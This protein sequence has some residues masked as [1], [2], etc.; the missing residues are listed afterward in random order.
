[1]RSRSGVLKWTVS[2]GAVRCADGR[3]EGKVPVLA[4]TEQD[5]DGLNG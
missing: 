2:V 4:Q 3:Y 5:S 1:M